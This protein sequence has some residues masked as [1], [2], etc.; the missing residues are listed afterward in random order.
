MFDCVCVVCVSVCECV[1]AC[2]LLSVY[3]NACEFLSVCECVYSCELL[4]V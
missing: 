1:F 4:S 3:V 2:E